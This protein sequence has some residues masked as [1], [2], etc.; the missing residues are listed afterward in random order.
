MVLPILMEFTV[1][2]TQKIKIK[3][4]DI[5]TR[6]SS[7]DGRVDDNYKICIKYFLKII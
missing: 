2:H 3:I 7:N 4:K 6:I 5:N 1:P